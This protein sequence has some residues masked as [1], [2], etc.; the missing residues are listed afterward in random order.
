MI[1]SS[2]ED[3]ADFASIESMYQDLESL[4]DE[5][6]FLNPQNPFHAMRIMRN[7]INRASPSEREI[8]TLRGI[9]RQLR[10]W[11]ERG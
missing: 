2:Q 3:L 9:F 8:R 10:W 5:S 7:L 6:G 4:L 11:K 1:E